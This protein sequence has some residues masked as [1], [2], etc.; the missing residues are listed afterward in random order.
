VEAALIS[1][2]LKEKIDQTDWQAFWPG[3]KPVAYCIY[4]HE[5]IYLFNHPVLP[6]SF[7]KPYSFPWNEQFVGDTLILYK[8][9]PTA[10]VN[11][12]RYTDQK[13]GSVWNRHFQKKI[14]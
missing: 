3:F 8:D 11:V 6:G 7:E 10:I 13:N 1:D 4:D 2:E 12:E 9:Y 5:K 14:Q